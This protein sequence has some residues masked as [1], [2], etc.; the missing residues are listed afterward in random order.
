MFDQIPSTYGLVE[1]DDIAQ[2]FNLDSDNLSFEW[3][4][5]LNFIADT[6]PEQRSIVHSLALLKHKHL[7]L[8]EL[9][10]TILKLLSVAAVLPLST[11]EVERVFSQVKLIKNDHRNRLK[12]ETLE[13]LLHVKIN[14]NKEMFLSILESV[15]ENFFKV[16]QRRLCNFLR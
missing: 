8:Q 15:V 16:K 12:Q 7:G 13:N 5:F 11:A 1:I 10:P 2:H 14:C 4:S 3:T 6:P 9:Y